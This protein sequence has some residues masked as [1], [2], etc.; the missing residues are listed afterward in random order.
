[1]FKALGRWLKAVGYL[2]TGQIDAARRTLDANPAVVRARYD[3]VI[4]EKTQRIHQYKQAVAQL[5]AQE[6]QKLAKI[7]ALGE[8]VGKLEA[9]KAGALAK[10]KQITE[11]LKAKGVAAEGIKADV[12]YQRCLSAYNDFTSTLG[13]KSQRIQ[14]LEADVETYRKSI[15]DHKVQLQA[16]L[17][18]LETLRGEAAE[19]VADVITAK[20]EK[21]IADTLAGIAQDGSS[22]E[23]QRLRTMRHELR[24]EA[25][26]SRE[27][28]GTDNRAQE[29][30]FLEYAR[31]N[32]A[33]DE[34]DRLIG[35]AE[36]S[37]RP[38]AASPESATKTALPE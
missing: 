12:D 29:A 31:T 32:A 35:L 27:L 26:V 28:A 19:A 20:Q 7:R 5:I 30:E 11:A 8:E 38:A 1:M 24:A 6:E 9:L 3:S 14:E 18:E 17:R 22:E 15:G 23:L 16:L 21:E 2:F 25:R 4:T 36:A 34:F 13:E 37:D 10:A 33:S